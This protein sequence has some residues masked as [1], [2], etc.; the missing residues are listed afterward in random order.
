MPKFLSGAFILVCLGKFAVAETRL[1]DIEYPR[2]S[3]IDL[4]NNG[5]VLTFNSTSLQ[6]AVV[7]GL[8]LIV[9]ALVV[10]QLLGVNTNNFFAA[11]NEYD[12]PTYS[13][14]SDH[15]YS[16]YSV[17]AQRSLDVLSP[18]MQALYNAYQKYE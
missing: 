4:T 2:F 9:L 16:S 6:Y 1:D 14:D 12:S 8:V 18:I 17:Y 13:Y 3:F 5:A 7:T 15:A 11:K 10:T